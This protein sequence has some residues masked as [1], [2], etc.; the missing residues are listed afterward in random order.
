M[1]PKLSKEEYLSAVGVKIKAIYDHMVN[2]RIP[3][4]ESR[5]LLEDALKFCR[6]EAFSMLLWSCD[7]R[8]GL[9]VDGY[10]RQALP[11]ILELHISADVKDAFLK[12]LEYLGKWDIVVDFIP[13]MKSRLVHKVFAEIFKAL[14]MRN[15]DCGVSMP[16]QGDVANRIRGLKDLSP[17]EWRGLITPLCRNQVEVMMSE[18]KWADIQ[19][20]R[21]PIRVIGMYQKAFRKHD[22]AR[23][24]SYVGTLL[25]K[26]KS[27]MAAIASKKPYMRRA[28]PLDDVMKKKYY[29]PPKRIETRPQ[30][31]RYDSGRPHGEP[32]ETV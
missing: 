30:T 9:G 14:S 20:E 2:K 16:R 23:F 10:V 8:E 7:I 29:H 12:G 19:Y 32:K 25:P 5:T 15:V 11:F 3:D 1:N 18:G 4:D 13:S 21:L 6:N 31:R 22:R 24:E 27:V 26:M 17:K 28:A